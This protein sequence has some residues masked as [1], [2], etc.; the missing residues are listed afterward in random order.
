MKIKA[1]FITKFLLIICLILSFHS[2]TFALQGKDNAGYDRKV[3]TFSTEVSPTVSISN[4]A[5]TGKPCITWE[6]LKGANRY[7]VYCAK[8]KK[9]NYKRLITTSAS[10]F[11]HKKAVAGKTYYY[12][13]QAVSKRSP[14]KLSKMSA[15]RK[16]ICDLRSPV[17]S[18][19]L[20]K[21]GKPKV[22]WKAVANA[23]KYE[24]Y[25]ATKENGSYKK[26]AMVKG[27][28]YTH[29][30]ASYDKDYYYKVRA[31]NPEFKGAASAKSSVCSIYT[32]DLRK[33]RIALTFDDGPGPYTQRIVD[34]LKEH[35]GRATFYLLGMNVEVYPDVV[36]AMKQAGNEIG[37]HSYDHP[38]L[39]L[40]TTDI[41]LSQMWKT[42]KAIEAVIG[43]TT[44]TMRPP[45]GKFNSTVQAI[46]GKPVIL[47]S[48]TTLD[49]YHQDKD[50]TVKYVMSNVSDGDVI[51]MHDIHESTMEAVI[52]L[53]PKLQCEGYE[54]VT[55]SELAKY[56]GINLEKGKVYYGFKK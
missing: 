4:V 7:K 28:S 22:T 45:Y 3:K 2:S 10:S 35:N 32:M 44:S 34:C 18:V 50:L 25:C 41:I 16:N 56:R 5:A 40:Q 52:E 54:L 23:K 14:K 36:K 17:C 12:K 24:I 49:W 42:D 11:V 51:L 43:E 33:K 26:I 27:T 29:K 8:S 21:R 37:N 1:G 31:T 47:W 53:V 39:R 46:V 30:E 6:K 15:P 13:V 9:G 20:N 19:N 48:M 55:V 38:N